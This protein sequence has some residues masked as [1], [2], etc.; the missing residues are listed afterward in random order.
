MLPGTSNFS[1]GHSPGRIT[2]FADCPCAEYV[3]HAA[4]GE[5]H[6]YWTPPPPGC[7][8]APICG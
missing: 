7:S 8:D 4:N 3:C 5:E 6:C 2:A 1:A